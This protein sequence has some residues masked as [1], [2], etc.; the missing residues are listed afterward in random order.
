MPE[1]GGK[2]SSVFMKQKGFELLFQ[3]PKEAYRQA[4][5]YAPFEAFEACGFDDAFPT[6]DACDV[7]VGGK[8]VRY[9]D[10]GEIWS[11]K[12]ECKMEG[13]GVTLS[14]DSKILPCHYEK[15]VSLN[16]NS[17][18][19]RYRI[20]NTGEDAF[21]Y[22]WVCHCLVNLRPNMKLILPETHAARETVFSGERM[23]KWYYSSPVDE[24]I[25]GY[26]YPEQGV[27]A[28]ISYDPG[29]LP[30]L[31]FWMTEGGFRGDRNCA[32]EPATGYYDSIPIALKNRA[33]SVLNPKEAVEFELT[34]SL[35]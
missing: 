24:G 29:K 31:G 5:L 13:A 8:A 3:N 11:A 27:R 26:D 23:E 25:C 10:H 12:M 2:I 4:E 28:L 30:Y 33:C 1:H 19:C 35:L 15:R 22:L 7:T 32:L 21:P 6:V 14:Y 18:V 16:E 34:I 17:V 9:P 20:I